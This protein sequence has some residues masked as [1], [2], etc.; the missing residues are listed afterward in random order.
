M[1]KRFFSTLWALGLAMWVVPGALVSC[2]SDDD[3]TTSPQARLAF[4]TDTVAFD[5]VISGQ[6]ANTRT[7]MVYNRNED[8]IRLPEV[9]LAGGAE[10]AFRVN[11]DGTFLEN[12]SG[13]GFEIAGKDSMYV[14]VEMTPP[15]NQT[16]EPVETKDDLVFTTEGG[17]R[18]AVVLTAYGQDVEPL[19]A[20]VLANDTT[21]SSSKPYQIFDSLVV[22]SGATL[23]I[24]EGVRLYFHPDSR[25]IV[26]GTLRVEGTP[27]NPVLMRGDRL[28]NMFTDQPYDRIP[29][30]WGGVEFTAES[31]GNVISH[32]DIHSGTFGLRCDSSGTEREKLRVENSILHNFSGDALYARMSRI[33]VGN[34]Q[35]TNAG[36]NC[37]T[38]YGGDN[39]FIHCTIGNFY[40]FT[41]GRGVALEFFNEDNGIPLPLQRADFANCIITGYSSDEIMGHA[42]ERYRDELFNYSFHYCLL[43]TPNTRTSTSSD[44]CGTTTSTKFAAMEISRPSSI[45]TVSCFLSRCRPH[46]RRSVRPIPKLRAPTIPRIGTGKAA[47]PTGPPIWAVTKAFL[48]KRKTGILLINN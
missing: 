43:N 32:A 28:G 8:A 46:R 19:Y 10:S 47:L 6:P 45:S 31:L 14:F 5:T 40:A 22:A 16:D 29:A 7:F 18:Q 30:Q 24:S 1:T 17:V 37:V 38:L 42:S 44:A 23:T 34:T 3:Y 9:S 41:G 2:M 48:R 39:T 27:G 33:F 11:V 4:S 21:L 15:V 12:G 13:S 25:L 36:G 35:I 20:R 26:H